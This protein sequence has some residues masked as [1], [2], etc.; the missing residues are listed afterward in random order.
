MCLHPTLRRVCGTQG[1]LL[2]RC[3]GGAKYVAVL[4]EPVLANQ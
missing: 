4:P 3:T 2:W 1:A